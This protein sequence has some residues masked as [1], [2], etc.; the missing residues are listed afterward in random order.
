MFR[1]HPRSL[2]MS[3]FDDFLFVFNRNAY[4]FILYRFRDI[5][6]YLSKFANFSLPHIWRFPLGVIPFEF[7]EVLWHQK[8]R[9]TRL[10]CSVVCVMLLAIIV[11]HGLVTGRQTH[12]DS[13]T[14]RQT[15]KQTHCH[16][17]YCTS[18]VSRGKYTTCQCY[19]FLSFDNT[20]YSLHCLQAPCY[21]TCL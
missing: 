18:F 7:D 1:G 19:L 14:D 5:A 21:I 6:S 17:K 13:Q 9:V 16:N 11:E 10:S 15:H 2:A 3:P 4:A 20:L 8:T 12:T